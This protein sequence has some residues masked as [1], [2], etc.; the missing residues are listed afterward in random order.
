MRRKLQIRV[1]DDDPQTT[2][3]WSEKLRKIVAAP[4]TVEPLLHTEFEQALD[5]LESRR[6]NARRRSK[7]NIEPTPCKAI[8]EA[9]VLII[10]YDLLKSNKSSFLTG[11]LFAYLS[12]CYS[13]CG[14]ILVVNQFSGDLF[15]LTLKGHPESFADLNIGASQLFCD[16][17]WKDDWSNS[18]RSWHWPVLPRAAKA[19]RAR[20]AALAKHL[21][22][23][24][25]SYLGMADFFGMLSGPAAEFLQGNVRKKIDQIT[26]R[27]FVSG[28]S[29]H[30][31]QRADGATDDAQ[32]ARIAVSRIGKWL[33]RLILVGQD[34]LVDAPHLVSRIPK[35]LRGDSRKIANWNETARF[36]DRAPYGIRTEKIGSCTFQGNDWLSRPAWIWPRLTELRELREEALA[37]PSPGFTFCEDISRFLPQPKTR[38][39]VADLPSPFV[40]RY[41]ANPGFLGKRAREE[42]R[43][44][45]YAPE[46]RFAI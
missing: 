37:A 11:E 39:F 7:S 4:H 25:I 46:F 17:L 22:R 2:R 30:G 14:L 44:I 45:R 28:N 3:R 33:E 42:L 13:T 29:I 5:A 41:V 12:R 21:D 18:Y 8:D 1:H 9:D 31:L 40:K 15:D 20:S 43:S 26:F 23:A 38:Q 36:G 27:D 19:F 16:G 6:K 34:I 35:L 10:D 32:I 24:V